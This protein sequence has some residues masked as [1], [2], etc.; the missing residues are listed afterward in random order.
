MIGCRA[1]GSA[2]GTSGSVDHFGASAGERWRG[3]GHTLRDYR[4]AILDTPTTATNTGRVAFSD[5]PPTT[6]LSN[7]SQYKILTM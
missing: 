3:L 5:I 7:A 2:Y 6:C 4:N 1:G